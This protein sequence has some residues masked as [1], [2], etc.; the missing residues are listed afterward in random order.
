[1]V[2]MAREAAFDAG[3]VEPGGVIAPGMQMWS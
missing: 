1:M 3:L 2:R